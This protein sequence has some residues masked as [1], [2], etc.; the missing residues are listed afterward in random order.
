MESPAESELGGILHEKDKDNYSDLKMFL[1]V[2]LSVAILW[3]QKCTLL[4][5]QRTCSAASS[6]YSRPRH[7][8]AAGPDFPGH[9]ASW[10]ASRGASWFP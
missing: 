2:S 7:P 3:H 5:T 6:I 1:T 8:R 10:W 4:L 9:R